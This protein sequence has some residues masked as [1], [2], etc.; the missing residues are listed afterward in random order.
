MSELQSESPTSPPPPKSDQQTSKSPASPPP[1]PPPKS[2]QETSETPTLPPP[3]VQLHSN[4][5]IL[6]EIVL[7]RRKQLNVGILAAA[8]ATWIVMDVYHYSFITLLSWVAIALLSCLFFW[9]T[10]HRFLKKEAPD[11]SELEISEETAKA[12]AGL[13]RRRVEDG[14]RLMFHVGSEREWFVFV[15]AVAA[16]YILSLAAKHLNFVTLCFIGI[17]GAMTVPVIYVK[18]EQKI[19]EFEGS[20]MMR[21]QRLNVMFEE[22]FQIVK[23]KIGGKQKEVKEKKT[24]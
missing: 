16:L 9:G 2:D 12:Q 1:S 19:R 6:R 13:L 10:I 23:S 21:W 3:K 5:D 4:S 11:L 17:W 7:W 8:T 24:K 22:K 18:N 20:A 14:I 15:G